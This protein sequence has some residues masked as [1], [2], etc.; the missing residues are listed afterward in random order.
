MSD[1]RDLVRER[2]LESLD[3]IRTTLSADDLLRALEN[4][5]LLR[6]SLA[7]WVRADSRAWL[8]A[9]LLSDLMAFNSAEARRRLDLWRSTLSDGDTPELSE[10]EQRVNDRVRQK[11]TD[12]IVLGTVHHCE[13]LWQQAASLESGAEPPHPQFMLKTYYH[14]AQE[15][16]RAAVAEY[17]SIGRLSKLRDQ[18][19]T[20]VA[21]RTRAATLYQVAL[22]QDAYPEALDALKDMTDLPLIPHFHVVADETSNELT[23]FDGMIARDE[24]RAELER[25]G[26][27][28]A[29]ERAQ[30]VQQNAED[31]L[32][33]CQ[34]QSALGALSG[35]ERMT[36]FLKPQMV[37]AL[38]ELNTRAEDAIRS[39]EQ[40]ER[41]ARQAI[42]VAD[43]NPLGAWDVYVEAYQMYAGAPAL[44]QA[45]ETVVSRLELQLGGLLEQAEGAFDNRDMARVEELV[46]QAQ[47]Y[48]DIDNSLDALL[49]R[50]N[51]LNW[52]AQSYAEYLRKADEV[53]AAARELVA[54][55]AIRAN[56]TLAQLDDF[57][58]FVLHDI[59][60]FD[61]L[62]AHV[63]Q[64]ADMQAI[65]INLRAL[66]N[67]DNTEEIEEAI[68]QVGAIN[69]QPP[70][71]DAVNDLRLHLDYLN[72]Q[73]GYDEGET[74]EAKPV[75]PAAPSTQNDADEVADDAVSED[76][77]EEDEEDYA[78]QSD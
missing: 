43:A 26:R 72:G 65:A 77:T 60:D 50:L 25:L 3:R 73:D 64:Q 5:D 27:A 21:Q 38:A 59:P 18:A 29:A 48:D 2:A 23:A 76:G 10:Y 70:V 40:A 22:E 53:I 57:P 54:A 28:W 1:S 62:R 4:I 19:D 20:I 24:A 45:R 67:S 14:K 75:E 41:R 49:V 35:Y 17:P 52:Q 36:R 78:S 66:L 33:L 51:E 15:V 71:S 46:R 61:I 63:S 12:L 68:A 6:A 16:T 42:Q 13:S 55:D 8:D 9:A 7:E 32:T 34:P 11:Q 39:L 69:V 74:E 31:A 37:E 44:P 58:E 56:E 30:D 47:P